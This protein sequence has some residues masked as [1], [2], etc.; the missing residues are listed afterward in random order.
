MINRMEIVCFLFKSHTIANHAT[1]CVENLTPLLH[2]RY[3]R[4]CNKWQKE[5]DLFYFL[6]VLNKDAE[7]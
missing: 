3:C 5:T 4:I 1:E 7:L 2:I 6:S